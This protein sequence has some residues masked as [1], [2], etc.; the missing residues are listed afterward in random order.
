MA[1]EPAIVDRTE[2]DVA[3]R[4]A[5]RARLHG[6]SGP[7]CARSRSSTTSSRSADDLP[8][9]L[10]RRAGGRHLPAAARATT[11]RSSATPSAR[12][13]GSA[14]CS[15]RSWR[16][17]ARGAA[18]D[19]ALE[20]EEPERAAA[21]RVPR[22]ALVRPARDRH[23]GP[24]LHAATATSTP[25]TRPAARDA[26][27]VAVNCAQAGG[28]C[29]CV[30]MDTGPARDRRLRPGA[31]RAARRRRPPLPR[32]GRA[33]SA[34]PRCSPRSAHRAGRAG[35]EAR[36]ADAAVARATRAQM[37]R[38]ARRHRH[39]RPAATRNAEHPRWDEVADRCLTL[40]Q[41]HDG[42]PDLLLHAPSRTR[43]TWPAR[44]PSACALW[45]SCFTLD[46]SYIHGGSVRAARRARATA[47]G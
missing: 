25:T 26:F 4:R 47:S 1:A 7:P 6:R 36:R 35:D 42:L 23:P 19:G 39:P 13:A 8:G 15:R 37:G 27:I 2:L 30:S 5:A 41:L 3:L 43:P 11:R 40:R 38:D 22:R 12:L 24:R 17:G 33:A 46:H 9:G 45:D 31:D 18:A 34:A 44:R 21:L 20:V 28:T 10:D 14:S 16:S 32:R 29:F